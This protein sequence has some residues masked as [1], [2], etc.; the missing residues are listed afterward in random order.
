M[1]KK[2]LIMMSVF[3]GGLNIRRQ[4]TSILKQNNVD[5]HILIRDDGSDYETK[6]ILKAIQ[7]EFPDNITCSFDE[8]VGWKQSFM[9]LLFNAE[10]GYDYY[11]FSDQDDL[12][13]EDKVISCINLMEKDPQEGIKL[14]HC[15]S[16]SVDCNL[17]RREEQEFRYACPPSHKAAIATEYFQ[18]C[19][20]LWNATA[21]DV[22][23]HTFRLCGQ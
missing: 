14:A 6:K 15:N 13:M 16:L 12:W 9:S 20:M 11:G 18:G 10:V 23:I 8:N 2:V 1:N 21:M 19:G 7:I 17:Q 5:V 3:N 22:I 4:I